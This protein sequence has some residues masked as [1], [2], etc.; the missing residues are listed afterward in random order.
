M[1]L[2]WIK[3]FGIGW[4]SAAIVVA[5]TLFSVIITSLVHVIATGRVPL[6]SFVISVIAA[7]VISTP[8]AYVSLSIYMQIKRAHDEVRRLSVTD[9]LTGVFNRR[10]FVDRAKQ[11]LARARRYDGTFAIVM[12]DVDAFKSVNDTHGHLVGDIVLQ[13]IA[14]MCAELC[15]DTDIFARFGGEEF[16][17]LLTETH[18]AGALVFAERVRTTV[19]K[20]P[21]MTSDTIVRLTVSVG[22]AAHREGDSELATLIGRADSAVYCAKSEGK[23]RVRVG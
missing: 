22:V 2:A 7:A 17:F 18:E 8:F 23:N 14:G 16:I 19:E 1:L 15:R 9:D 3:R 6:V 12:L 4:V 10:H 20:T 5:S 11:E 13:T 21:I